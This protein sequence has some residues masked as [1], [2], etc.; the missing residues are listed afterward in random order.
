MTN[1][2][3]YIAPLYIGHLFIIF[4]RPH[5]LV[6][7]D[8]S[9]ILVFGILHF[10]FPDNWPRVSNLSVAMRD[11]RILQGV[12]QIETGVFCWMGD[13]AVR[14]FRNIYLSGVFY[15]EFRCGSFPSRCSADAPLVDSE[16]YKQKCTRR[17]KEVTEF[18]SSPEFARDPLV[19]ILA[20]HILL[21]SPYGSRAPI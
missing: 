12:F 7:V 5:L 21:K 1:D 8:I 10:P 11:F 13:S 19:I 9:G 2:I 6:F 3:S 4:H 16:G 20:G 15:S 18:I 17:L 14:Q